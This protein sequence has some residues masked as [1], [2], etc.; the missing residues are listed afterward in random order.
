MGGAED[1]LRHLREDRMKLEKTA[2]V[3]ILSFNFI[4]KLYSSV[5]DK[6]SRFRFENFTD[7]TSLYIFIRPC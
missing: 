4:Q 5:V 1:D 3:R 6:T 2:R 7:M